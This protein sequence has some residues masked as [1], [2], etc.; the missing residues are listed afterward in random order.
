MDRAQYDSAREAF[1]ASGLGKVR[2]QRFDPRAGERGPYLF[3][4]LRV[5]CAT[6]NAQAMALGYVELS[7]ATGAS[8]LLSHYDDSTSALELAASRDL[9]AEEIEADHEPAAPTAACD[10]VA[11]AAGV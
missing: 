8:L 7:V 6:A 2:E 11:E 5:D 10:A 9:A 1:V 4:T 3:L